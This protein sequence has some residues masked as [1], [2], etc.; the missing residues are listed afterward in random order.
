MILTAPTAWAW[1]S[2]WSTWFL[3]IVFPQFLRITEKNSASSCS[4]GQLILS[5]PKQNVK[6]NLFSS[7]V[8]HMKK[9]G[10]EKAAYSHYHPCTAQTWSNWLPITPLLHSSQSLCVG[11]VF[12]L[13]LFSC[14][15]FTLSEVTVTW[16]NRDNGV[17]FLTH[18]LTFQVMILVANLVFLTKSMV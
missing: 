4:Q 5:L 7:P 11:R 2:G 6:V 13:L 15:I 1:W 3:F 12:H 14:S 10:L 9:P 16:Q 8:I 17:L 18:M